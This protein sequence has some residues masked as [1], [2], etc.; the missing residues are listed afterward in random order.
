MR[1]LK[2]RRFFLAFIKSYFQKDLFKV[3]DYF[4]SYGMLNFPEH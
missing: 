2:Y 4:L 3:I 1:E